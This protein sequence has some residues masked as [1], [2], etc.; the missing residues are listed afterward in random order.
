MSKSTLIDFSVEVDLTGI[1]DHFQDL[2][3]DDTTMLEVH[4]KFASMCDPYVPML[5]GPLHESA[6]AQVTPKYVRY[7]GTED[8]PYARYQYYGTEFNHTIEKHPQA[9]ALWDKVM[10]QERG[11]E[12][13]EAVKEILVRRYKELYG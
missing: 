7:G 1:E 5:N 2:C 8:V 12:F 6:F 11:E 3:H 13:S 10:M 9:T 4:N